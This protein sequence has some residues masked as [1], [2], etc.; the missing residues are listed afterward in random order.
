MTDLQKE[1]E[2]TVYI[3]VYKSFHQDISLHLSSLCIQWLERQV[4]ALRQPPVISS[5]YTCR[6][7]ELEK[8]SLVL[9]YCHNCNAYVQTDL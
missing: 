1:F 5:V 3:L 7:S 9:V 6:N 4:S 2:A 8:D